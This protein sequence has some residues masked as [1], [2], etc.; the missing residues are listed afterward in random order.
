MLGVGIGSSWRRKKH[1]E[2]RLAFHDV[3]EKRPENTSIGEGSNWITREPF[4]K[5]LSRGVLCL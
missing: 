4:R 1:S 5:L 3:Q 2:R